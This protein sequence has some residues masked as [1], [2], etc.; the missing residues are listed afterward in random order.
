M[1][2]EQLEQFIKVIDEGSISRAA[3]KMYMAQ[4]SL[5]TSIKRLEENLG[6]LLVKRGSDGVSLTEDGMEVYMRG[7]LICKQMEDMKAALQRNDVAR[8]N[9]SIANNYSVI[10]KDIFL[11]LYNSYKGEGHRFKIFDCSINEAIHHV[12]TGEAEIGLIRFPEANKPIH[13]RQIKRNGLVYKPVARKVICAIVGEKNPF[14]RLGM[15]SIKPEQLIDFSFVSYYDEETEIVYQSI[16]EERRKG[17]NIYIG[18]L[19]HLKEIIR[20][21]DAFALDVY[22]E[23]D[24]NSEENLGIKFI[25]LQPKLY[26]EFGWIKKKNLS[27]TDVGKAYIDMIDKK[28]KVYDEEPVYKK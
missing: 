11:D 25:P 26:S 2:L 21:T 16:I 12:S 28:F 15:K 10:G 5:S 9:L 23:E 24:F 8:Q 7:K 14:Y 3:M 4:S 6:T 27:L 17:T 1:K 18:S 20:D 19:Q 13:M 22:K